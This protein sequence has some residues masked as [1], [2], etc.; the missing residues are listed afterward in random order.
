MHR[1]RVVTKVVEETRTITIKKPPKWAASLRSRNT[2]PCCDWFNNLNRVWLAGEDRGKDQGLPGGPVPI[3]TS[4][5]CS[6]SRC[7]RID[8]KIQNASGG[9]GGNGAD[10]KRHGRLHQST[11]IFAGCNHF[12]LCVTSRKRLDRAGCI[13]DRVGGGK[14]PG[15]AVSSSLG[16]VR[17]QIHKLGQGNCRQ[18][19]QDNN[20]HHQLNQG[21]TALVLFHSSHLLMNIPPHPAGLPGTNDRKDRTY[22]QILV[23]LHR[24]VR[25]VWVPN[26]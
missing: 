20:H 2:K 11:H 17:F 6:S 26:V 5:R 13:V 24:V 7:G 19:A 18:H 12:A 14:S 25:E 1:R 15:C 10:R 8:R 9:S 16:S 21:K 22:R 4:T 23:L 3:N